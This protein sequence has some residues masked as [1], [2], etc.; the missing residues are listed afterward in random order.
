MKI[1]KA[2]AIRMSWQKLE[3]DDK[4]VIADWDSL[5]DYCRSSMAYNNIEEF[6]VIFL[7]NKLKVIDEE[8]QQRGT[9]TQ[10]NV[11]PREVVKSAINKEEITSNC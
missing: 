10:V 2:G 1:V 8:V 7:N 3:N 9:A 5:M 11:H 6:R 4:P